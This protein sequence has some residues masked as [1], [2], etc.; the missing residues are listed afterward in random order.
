MAIRSTE[1]GQGRLFW[2]NAILG[3][4]LATAASFL[5]LGAAVAYPQEIADLVT[6]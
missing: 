1:L 6:K 4:A 3:A 2:R 5:F